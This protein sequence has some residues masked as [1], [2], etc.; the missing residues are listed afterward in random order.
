MI[1]YRT[2]EGDRLDQICFNHYGSV[3]VIV[4]VMEANPWTASYA[5]LPAGELITLPDIDQPGLFDNA[6]ERV[7]D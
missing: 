6:N 1:E 2:K 5:V 4:R 3:D 7:W